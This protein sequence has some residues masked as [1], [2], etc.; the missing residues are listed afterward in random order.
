MFNFCP[1]CGGSIGQDHVEGQVLVCKHC[2]KRIGIV[3]SS[4]KKV[5]D[6]VEELIR[7]GAAAY[8]PVCQQL[9]ELKKQAGASTF[10]PHFGVSLQRRICPNSGKQ[11][12]TVPPAAPRLL[13]R[14][15][16]GRT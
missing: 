4:V 11:T 1:H 5:T 7:H 3:V 14:H 12:G 15:P 13:S 10:V 2:G 9:V 8:C 16:P 6:P